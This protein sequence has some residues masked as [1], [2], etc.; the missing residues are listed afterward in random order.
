MRCTFFEQEMVL[1]VQFLKSFKLKMVRYNLVER[2]Q[3][4]GE[5]KFGQILKMFAS[6]L[7]PKT[8]SLKSLAKIY[9]NWLALL[10]T[11][12]QGGGGGVTKK[13]QIAKLFEI[14]TR[15]YF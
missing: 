1:F 6:F 7:M 15:T 9:S 12:Q 14:V 11:Y 13:P 2:N 8:S 10:L 3:M 5:I 4:I